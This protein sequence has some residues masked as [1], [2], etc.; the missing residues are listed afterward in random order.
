MIV[1][2]AVAGNGLVA[3]MGDF[4]SVVRRVLGDRRR[5][6]KLGEQVVEM[7]P[8]ARMALMA[9]ADRMGEK[10]WPMRWSVFRWPMTGPYGGVATGRA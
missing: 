7:E 5:K 1:F 6:L 9:S 4:R 8:A 3:V 2:G 10:L